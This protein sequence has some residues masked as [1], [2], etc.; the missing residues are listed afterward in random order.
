MSNEI[1]PDIE[2]SVCFLC[3]EESLD[4]EISS[5]KEPMSEVE[6]A[7]ILERC[8]LVDRNGWATAPHTA[9]TDRA[10]IQSF[11]NGANIISEQPLKLEICHVCG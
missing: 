1:T 9:P 3:S 2:A 11:E 7:F 4:I 5:L 10:D 6:L 8:P